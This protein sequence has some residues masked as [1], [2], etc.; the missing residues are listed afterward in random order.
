MSS[1]YTEE[2]AEWVKKRD[3]EKPKRQD[4]N[5]VAFL[6]VSNDVKAAIVA[7]YSLMTIWEHMH[8]TGKIQVRYETFTKYVRR[9][10]NRSTV[11][12]DQ[13]GDK[14]TAPEA[15]EQAQ[16]T[17]PEPVESR[18]EPKKSEPPKLGGFTFDAKPKREE[19]I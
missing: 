5:W 18:S 1:S 9:H 7:G 13:G 2:L 6:A 16:S 3:A 11:Q 4:K 17:K 19:L 12:I 10:G 14:P 15:V 8:E